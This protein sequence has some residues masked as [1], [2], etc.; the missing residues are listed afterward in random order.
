LRRNDIDPQ[1]L[2]LDWK[3]VIS[4]LVHV[5]VAYLIALPIGWDRERTGQG[6]G[7]R[8]FPLVALA[9]CG[10]L[11]VMQNPAGAENLDAQSRVLQGLL[12]GIGFIGGG[13]ILKEGGTVRGT[14]TAVSIWNT[15]AIGVAVAFNR[16]EI[17]LVLGLVNFLTLKW[18]TPLGE[19]IQEDG[20]RTQ[21][22]SEDKPAGKE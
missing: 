18:L 4:N 10:Y 12:G 20:I 5:L 19:A 2:E 22:R 11:L 14:V 7:L 17:A 21:A 6:V 9:S 15:G 13:A 1:L 8:T 3:V 16:F